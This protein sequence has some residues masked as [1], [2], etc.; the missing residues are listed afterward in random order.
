[1]R[2]LKAVRRVVQCSH[3]PPV[4]AGLFCLTAAAIAEEKSP[5]GAAAAVRPPSAPGPF[6]DAPPPPPPAFRPAAQAE[7]QIERPPSDR[8][9]AVSK[10]MRRTVKI[11]CRSKEQVKSDAR[12]F[13]LA[14]LR[15]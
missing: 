15:T 1:M 7:N 3:E 8:E 12:G 14:L 4:P 10:R 2:P 13:V 5:H 6:A 11:S 9:K